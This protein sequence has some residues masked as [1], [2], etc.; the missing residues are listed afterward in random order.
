MSTEE[1]RGGYVD[2]LTK[3][4]QLT[5]DAQIEITRARHHLE[6]PLKSRTDAP[7]KRASQLEDSLRRSL[8]GILEAR[9]PLER[10]L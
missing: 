1:T 4:L 6:K 8:T 9:K 5:L 3:A 7:Q 10:V 2:H